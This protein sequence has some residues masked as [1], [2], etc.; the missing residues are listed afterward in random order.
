MASNLQLGPFRYPQRQ[1]VRRPWSLRL[2]RPLAFTNVTMAAPLWDENGGGRSPFLTA[3][4]PGLILVL[5][6]D[7]RPPRGADGDDGGEGGDR[8][9]R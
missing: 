5:V 3:T 9:A 2:P 7:Y 4:Q 8:W 1:A 6:T